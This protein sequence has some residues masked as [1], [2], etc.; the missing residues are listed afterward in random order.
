MKKLHILNAGCVSAE[1]QKTTERFNAIYG[2]VQAENNS[3]GSVDRIRRILRGEPCD[4]LIS[5]DDAIIANMLMPERTKGYYIFAGNS[6]VLVAANQEKPITGENWRQ[7]LLDPANTFGHYNPFVD[8]GGYRSV[9]ACMLADSV[10]PGLSKKLLEHPGRRI[11]ASAKDS[12]ADFSFSYR[13]NAVKNK[14]PFA[15][16]PESMN[17]SNPALNEHY[18]TAAFDLDGDG[19]NVVRGSAICHALTVPQSAAEPEL[20]MKFVGLFLQNDF[21]KSGFLPL[22]KAVGEWTGPTL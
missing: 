4:L 11:Y 5:A 21:K 7:A 8:P 9:M 2:D 17:L 6:M 10:E 18:A 19:G 15:Q 20:A 1:V 13:S 12:Q 14:R 22:S 16:L 3:G